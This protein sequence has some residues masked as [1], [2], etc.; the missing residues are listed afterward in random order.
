[1]YAFHE[2]THMH[3]SKTATLKG[4]FLLKGKNSP[5]DK[6]IS[7][8]SSNLNLIFGSIIHLMRNLNV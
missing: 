5:A 2:T 6:T 4:M 3:I 7:Q 1:M 8:D